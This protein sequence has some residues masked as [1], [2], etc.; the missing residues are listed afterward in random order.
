M[1]QEN[2]SLQGIAKRMSEPGCRTAVFTGAGM[3]TDSGLSDF[4]SAKGIWS[5][6]DPMELAT[7]S[8][9][10][11]NYDRFHEFYS[12]RLEQMKSAA[13][14]AGHKI[15]AD[16]EARG[17]V[18]CIITQNVDCLHA[19]AGSRNI[20]ELHGSVG[21]VRCMDCS[22]PATDEDFIAKK[23]CER[24]GG[25]LRPGVVLFSENLPD[26]ALDDSWNAAEEAGVFIVL[27]SSLQV[28]PANHLPVIARRAGAMLAICNHD[29][30][31]LDHMADYATNEGIADFLATLDALLPAK[32]A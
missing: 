32:R 10:R 19:A 20:F 1:A 21:K 17:F 14:N 29:A 4:R 28:S 22:C 25:R 23:P 12:L 11:N 18:S 13:P 31:P 15:L 6:L 8:A 9:M 16:W 27:G 7:A 2:E 3:S 5:K 26:R 24:C 30:T